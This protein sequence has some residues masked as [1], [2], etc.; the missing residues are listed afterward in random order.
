MTR[1]KG[2]ETAAA[3]RADPADSH[4][5]G[6]T[7]L[8]TLLVHNIQR[9]PPYHHVP[10]AFVRRGSQFLR[11]ASCMPHMQMSGHQMGSMQTAPWKASRQCCSCC[12][13]EIALECCV[14]SKCRP[15]SGR[16]R[17]T[18]QPTTYAT[19]QLHRHRHVAQQCLV[20]HCSAQGLG[21]GLRLLS[22]FRCQDALAAFQRLSPSQRN[23]G[24]CPNCCALQHSHLHHFLAH[25]GHRPAS[26]MS[27]TCVQPTCSS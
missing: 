17:S 1:N 4:S 12:R 15:G 24:G 10:A 23:T 25:E 3:Q 7:A 20:P 21:A 18:A 8:G 14:H 16:F 2:K 27:V 6:A 11:L 22:L 19:L 9:V 13:W 26:H 5:Q